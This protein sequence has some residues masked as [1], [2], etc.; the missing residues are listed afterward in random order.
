MKK[1]EEKNGLTAQLLRIEKEND[2]QVRQ[3]LAR[4]RDAQGAQLKQKL[5]EASDILTERGDIAGMSLIKLIN[6]ATCVAEML[7]PGSID[8]AV[9]FPEIDQAAYISK[10]CIDDAQVAFIPESCSLA[11][12][13]DKRFTETFVVVKPSKIVDTIHIGEIFAQKSGSSPIGEDILWII[14]W[15]DDL[16]KTAQA[17]DDTTDHDAPNS[18]TGMDN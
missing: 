8:V 4:L 5:K 14:E 13:L 11:V 2:R 3:D 7:H 18:G 17:S 16:I 9:G 15:L 12:P 6:P 1:T 10:F